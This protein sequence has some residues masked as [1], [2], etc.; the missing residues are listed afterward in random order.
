MGAG[1][2]S[3]LIVLGGAAYVFIGIVVARIAVVRRVDDAVSDFHGYARD[4]DRSMGYVCGVFWPVV[5]SGFVV[6]L[7][8]KPWIRGGQTFADW[9]VTVIPDKPRDTEEDA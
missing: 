6:Y 1:A 9:L 7:F 3:T 4:D 8:L 5:V 2:W